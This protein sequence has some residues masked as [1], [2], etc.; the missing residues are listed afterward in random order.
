MPK[1]AQGLP[2]GKDT[3]MNVAVQRPTVNIKEAENVG[4]AAAK[5]AEPRKAQWPSA[6]DPKKFRLFRH[7]TF[8]P[9][10]PTGLD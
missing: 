2:L 7:G 10:R 5:V 1:P 3:P 6:V 4:E 9:E 8:G